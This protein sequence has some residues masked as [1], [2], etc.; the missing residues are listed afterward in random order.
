MD[1][2]RINFKQIALVA[3]AVIVFMLLADFNNRWNE[4]ERLAAQYAMALEQR[5]LLVQT[6]TALEAAIDYT[7]SDAAVEAWAYGQ[8]GLARP[9]DTVIVPL[10]AEGGAPTA[11]PTPAPEADPRSNWEIWWSLFFEARE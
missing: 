1:R 4:K 5:E 8:A 6:Q 11:T 7:Q 2:L 10:P 9:G 3:A